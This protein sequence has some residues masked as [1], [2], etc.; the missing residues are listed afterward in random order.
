MTQTQQ[1]PRESLTIYV[2]TL[3]GLLTTDKFAP[4]LIRDIAEQAGVTANNYQIVSGQGLVLAK[5]FLKSLETHPTEVDYEILYADSKGMS[6]VN[7]KQNLINRLKAANEDEKTALIMDSI[8]A[9]CE[10]DEHSSLSTD[11]T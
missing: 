7:N 11:I 2:V 10:N 1:I 3:T 5:D 4:I 9:E 6:I 8:L